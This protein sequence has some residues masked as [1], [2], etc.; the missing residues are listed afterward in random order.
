MRNLK[1]ISPI[2]D[3]LLGEIRRKAFYGMFFDPFKKVIRVPMHLKYYRFGP[4]V[5]PDGSIVDQDISISHLMKDQYYELVADNT[6]W[7]DPVTG[8]FV[9]EGTQGAVGQYDL[10]FSV[11]S[12]GTVD[13]FTMLDN[14]IARADSMGRFI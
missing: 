12:S 1:T 11:A 8:A 14:E 13:I 10:F 7:C 5:M 6:T 4:V 3:P 9:A 2:N